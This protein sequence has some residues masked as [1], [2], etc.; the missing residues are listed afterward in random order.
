MQEL[1]H[2]ALPV[3]DTVTGKL[4]CEQGYAL[5]I[6]WPCHQDHHTWEASFSILVLHFLDFDPLLSNFARVLLLG[7]DISSNKIKGN[8]KIEIPEAQMLHLRLGFS[9]LPHVDP[10]EER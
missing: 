9:L 1:P 4:R 6:F 2:T 7:C 5:M 10:V 8:S 3:Y